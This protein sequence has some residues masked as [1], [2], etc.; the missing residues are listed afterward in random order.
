MGSTQ[1]EPMELRFIQ[2]LKDR[3]FGTIKV[4]RQ[5]QRPYNYYMKLLV[6]LDSQD[7]AS[8]NFL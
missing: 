8:A 7:S 1:S 5:F 2:V 3:Y 6:N 4:Y